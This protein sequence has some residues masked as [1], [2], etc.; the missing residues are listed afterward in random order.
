MLREPTH[1]G[2]A[3]FSRLGRGVSTSVIVTAITR[4]ALRERHHITLAVCV[5]G[6]VGAPRCPAQ[7]W[8]T[9]E[10]VGRYTARQGARQSRCS[11]RDGEW[12]LHAMLS[13]RPL[14]VTCEVTHARFP[15]RRRTLWGVRS[16]IARLNAA[17]A[18]CFLDANSS[19]RIF[20]PLAL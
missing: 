5:A 2:V 19:S 13:G 17:M 4:R 11:R 3:H 9:A 18:N 12:R 16:I 6:P 7:S 15:L 1:H 8:K 20:N 10:M 14:H